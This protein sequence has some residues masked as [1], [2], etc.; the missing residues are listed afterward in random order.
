MTTRKD[1]H[2]IFGAPAG[3]R[4]PNQQIMRRF[5]GI[6]KVRR[7][8]ITQYL[9]NPQ[10]SKFVGSGHVKSRHHRAILGPEQMGLTEQTSSLGFSPPCFLG[11]VVIPALDR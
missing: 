5:E 10:P 4:T 9:P 1:A 8:E 3:I 2:W 11:V 7:S 6:N